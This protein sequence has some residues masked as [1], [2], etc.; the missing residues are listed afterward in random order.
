MGGIPGEVENMIPL[1]EEKSIEEFIQIREKQ[2]ISKSPSF[3][4]SEVLNLLPEHDPN[5]LPFF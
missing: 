4:I 1:L 5:A 3:T 2:K